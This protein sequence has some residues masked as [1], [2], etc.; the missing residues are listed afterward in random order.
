MAN[1]VEIDIKE[2]SSAINAAKKLKVK[3]VV[4]IAGRA[5]LLLAA[6][7]QASVYIRRISTVKMSEN[8]CQVELE[9]LV[10]ATNRAKELALELST[11]AVSVILKGNRSKINLASERVDSSMITGVWETRGE[12]K[13]APMLANLLTRNA[14]IMSIKDNVA[15]KPVPIHIRWNKN[16]VVAGMSDQYHGV[17]ITTE[18]APKSGDKAQELFIYSE[19]LPLLIEYLNEKANLSLSE[20]SVVVSTDSYILSLQ[21]VIPSEDTVTLTEI[22]TITAQATGSK[23]KMSMEAL[24][25]TVTRSLAVLNKED[26]LSMVS[27]EKKADT[28]TIKGSSPSGSTITEFIPYTAKKPVKISFNGPVYNLRDVTAAC[29]PEMSVRMSGRAVLFDF[30]QGS[31]DGKGEVYSILMFMAVSA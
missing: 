22:E 14:H 24:N 9:R 25:Q 31:A 4:L 2:F 26:N 11:G 16:G 28:L 15:E 30:A 18:K 3:D 19:W 8:T 29:V 20:R 12:G 6:Y 27:S 5:G 13:P 10:S 23:I 17:A 1:A 21:A 7:T